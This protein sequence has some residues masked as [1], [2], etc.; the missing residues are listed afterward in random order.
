MNYRNAITPEE[1]AQAGEFM[2]ANMRRSGQ[3]FISAVKV[4][5]GAIALEDGR[6]SLVDVVKAGL[7]LVALALLFFGGPI[8]RWLFGGA[9][10]TVAG[11][12][13]TAAKA[14]TVAPT[15]AAWTPSVASGLG[16]LFL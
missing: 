16:A 13:A 4:G 1:Q 14:A 9:A 8:W 10:G 5:P 15:V 12:A 6:V 11:V 2:C 3:A 7:P